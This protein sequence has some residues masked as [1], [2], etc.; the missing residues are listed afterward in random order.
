LDSF[1]VDGRTGLGCLDERL[2]A[3]GRFEQQVRN[4][5]RRDFLSVAKEIE[6]GLHLMGELCDSVEPEHAACAL[7]GMSGTKYLVE[8]IEIFRVLLK[9]Q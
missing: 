8:Q 3:V 2:Q 4:L 9:L 5:R 7:D 1:V 6:Q